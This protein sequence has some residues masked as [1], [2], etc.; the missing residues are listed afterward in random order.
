MP[1]LDAEVTRPYWS[2]V[3]CETLALE[4]YVPAT[5]PL[6]GKF[7]FEI[8]PEIFEALMFERPL[9]FPKKE[10]PQILEPFIGPVTLRI[11]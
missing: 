5:T 9:P 1:I 2:T 4:P 8:V 7:V 3:T 11:E 6:G 10:V